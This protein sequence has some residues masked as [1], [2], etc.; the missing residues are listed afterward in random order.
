MIGLFAEPVEV[1]NYAA[2]M[3][4]TGPGKSRLD[5]SSLRVMVLFQVP[6]ADSPSQVRRHLPVLVEL[7]ADDVARLFWDF[8]RGSGTD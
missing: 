7:V 5:V 4:Y 2:R 1:T 3:I 6:I 8:T